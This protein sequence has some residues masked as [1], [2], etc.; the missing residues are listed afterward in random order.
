[1]KEKY[2]KLPWEELDINL[3]TNV[4]KITWAL[5]NT[6]WYKIFEGKNFS[7][8]GKLQEIHQVSCPKFSF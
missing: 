1:M 5:E 4:I 8:F 6:V 7:K 3:S 2:Q